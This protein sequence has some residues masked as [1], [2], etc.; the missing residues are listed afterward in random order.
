MYFENSPEE[1]SP[2]LLSWRFTL[3]NPNFLG[4]TVVAVYFAAAACCIRAAL[5]S[6]QDVANSLAALWWLIA[7]VTI[8]LGINKQLNL[9]TLMIVIGRN[10]SNA[11]GWYG[12]RRQVQLVFTAVLAVFSLCALIWFWRRCRDFFEENR[13][14]L[15][16]VVVLGL[17]VVMRAAS[18]NHAFALLIFGFK[19]DQ[20][21]WILEISGSLLIAVGALR[22]SAG[23]R[24]G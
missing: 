21:A 24:I 11:G 18:I 16:G 5:K 22:R 7:I 8:M 23:D 13:L 14:V 15:A 10:I 6:R 12:R 4:W 1:A 9:Q 17:F 2:S 3:D 19:D 20:W